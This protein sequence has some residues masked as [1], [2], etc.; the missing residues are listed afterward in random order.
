M[1][2]GGESESEGVS[3]G[4]AQFAAAQPQLAEAP[5]QRERVGNVHASV[6]AKLVARDV[7]LF[8]LR[9]KGDEPRELHRSGRFQSAAAK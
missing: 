6:G 7:E 4:R 1:R 5:A 3:T 9:Q 8:E 2:F